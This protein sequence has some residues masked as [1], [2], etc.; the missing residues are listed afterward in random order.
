M[1]LV[2]YINDKDPEIIFKGSEN[3][4]IKKIHE[5]DLCDWHDSYFYKRGKFENLGLDTNIY[6]YYSIQTDDFNLK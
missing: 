2:R 3:E 5:L 1:R 4:I 6:D